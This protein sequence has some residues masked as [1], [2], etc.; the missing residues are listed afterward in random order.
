MVNNRIQ[1]IPRQ[2]RENELSAGRARVALS[3]TSA[4]TRVIC[5]R[6][7]AGNLLA[8]FSPSKQIRGAPVETFAVDD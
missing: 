2:S 6:G 8:M 4:V 7:S 5:A 1:V 3:A